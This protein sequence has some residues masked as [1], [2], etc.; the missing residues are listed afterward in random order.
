MS[1]LGNVL[2]AR[3]GV[4]CQ[5]I[6]GLEE[7]QWEGGECWAGWWVGLTDRGGLPGQTRSSQCK[8]PDVVL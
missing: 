1:A 8:G 2:L 4:D 5:V 7:K 6:E 3:A